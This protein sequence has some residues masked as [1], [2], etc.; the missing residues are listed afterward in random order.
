MK[1]LQITFG[2]FL[3][4]ASFIY[5]KICFSGKNVSFCHNLIPSPGIKNENTVNFSNLV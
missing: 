5:I 3:V 4:T 2:T 1:S